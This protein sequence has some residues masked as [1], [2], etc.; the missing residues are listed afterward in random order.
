[1]KNNRYV[2][3]SYKY[4]AVEN[5]LLATAVVQLVEPARRSC[6]ASRMHWQYANIS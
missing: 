6:R 2:Y 1:M 3:A 4:G 5:L